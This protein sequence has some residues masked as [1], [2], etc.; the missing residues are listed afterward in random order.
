MGEVAPYFGFEDAGQILPL[1]SKASQVQAL[2]G[3]REIDALVI[4]IGANDLGC[5]TIVNFCVSVA[6]CPGQRFPDSTSKLTLEA[7]RVQRLNALSGAYDRLA[8]RRDPL[9]VKPKRIYITQYF[10]PTHDDDGFPCDAMID[11]PGVG[12]IDHNEAIWA[13]DHVVH[14]LNKAVSAAAA[15]HRWTFVPGAQDGFENH[16][17]CAKG[18]WIV[19]LLESV[20]HQG[21]KGGTMH[22]NHAGHELIAGLVEKELKQDLLPGGEPRPPRAPAPK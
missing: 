12:K 16:G 22:P 10:D 2:V 7:T 19:Q 11:V 17:Y 4:S 14:G 1:P 9:V 5:G 20:D 3:G 8:S 21:D 18:H 15:K 6:Q 13:S